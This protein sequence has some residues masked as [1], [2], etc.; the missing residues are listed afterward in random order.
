M[1]YTF[2]ASVRIRNNGKAPASWHFVTLPNDVADSIK[3]QI[4]WQKRL[5]F[6]SIKTQATIWYFRRETSIFPDKKS[7]SYLLCIK[8]DIRKE[9]H[10]EEWS[11]LHITLI[12]L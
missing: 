11:S 8:K 7:C 10:I 3:K 9:L 1:E 2:Q 12:L 6:G 4:V 5:W